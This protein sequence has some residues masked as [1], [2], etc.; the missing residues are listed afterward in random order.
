M[1]PSPHDYF[2]KVVDIPPVQRYL[3][4]VHGSEY[5]FGGYRSCTVAKVDDCIGPEVEKVIASLPEGSVVLL[6]NVRFYNEEE[7]MIP[8]FQRSLHP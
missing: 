6:E 4:P 8:N 1:V 7:R 2:A 5:M 3:P